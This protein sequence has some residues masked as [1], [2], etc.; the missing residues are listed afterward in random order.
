[1]EYRI[2]AVRGEDWA[3]LRE[4]RLAALADPVADVAFNET[5]A[6]AA[7]QSED[8]WRRR[9][10]QGVEGRLAETF[11]GE[12][13]ADPGHWLGSVTVLD[14]GWAAQVVGVYVRPEHRGR[15]LAAALFEAVE[16]WAL[17]RAE[18][19]CLRLH[20]HERNHRAEGFYLRQGFGRTG[21]FVPDPKTPEFREHEMVRRLP[22][23]ERS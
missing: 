22:R 5:Y 19:E 14:E 10:N 20:V 16:D 18:V 3:Q 13:E 23:R 17:A 21:A 11:I 7:A 9:A 12:D 6:R 8:F 4:L 15:G 2:R 1:M